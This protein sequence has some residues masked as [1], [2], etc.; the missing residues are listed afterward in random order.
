MRLWFIYSPDSRRIVAIS[1]AINYTATSLCCD[2][3][4]APSMKQTMTRTYKFNFVYVVVIAAPT[5]FARRVKNKRRRKTI[6][7]S[8]CKINSRAQNFPHSL[9]FNGS[10]L[11][12]NWKTLMCG[13]C[14]WWARVVSVVIK[15]ASASS[16][17]RLEGL[18]NYLNYHTDGAGKWRKPD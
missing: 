11:V 16:W 8:K 7:H 6:L 14:C 13:V 2:E 3:S 4:K 12:S 17:C 15:L 10:K 5:L 18:K 9:N 1:H